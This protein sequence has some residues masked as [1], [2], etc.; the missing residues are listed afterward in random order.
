VN[1]T[2]VC[3]RKPVL[4]WMIMAGTILFGIIA[5]TRIGVS[6]YPD[7][8]NPTVTV[9]VSWPGASPEDIETG[10][11]NPI[12]DSMSQ[13]TGVLTLASSAQQGSARVTA[14]FD[15][16]RNIDLALQDTQ[17]K[18]AQ[19]QRTMPTS[20]LAPVVSKSNPDDQPI[21]T[22]GLSGPFSR[23]LLADIAR[24]QVE[25]MLETIPGVGQITTMG[26]LDRNIRIWVDSDKLVATGVTVTDVMS[27]IQ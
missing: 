12:E 8:D 17:A 24:Y 3:L 10:I 6:Q 2:D 7:V 21:M 19:V 14:T 27:A 15:L 26:Y 11:I 16:S 22:V 23:Q 18:I 9:S 20:A 25:D 13:V 4:A 5:V 1:I